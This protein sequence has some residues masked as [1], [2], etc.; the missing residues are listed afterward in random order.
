MLEFKQ[1]VYLLIPDARLNELLAAWATATFHDPA[2]KAR[3]VRNEPSYPQS[4]F[5]EV[6]AGRPLDME[7]LRAIFARFDF[8]GA[9][10]PEDEVSSD[11]AY[12]MLPETVSLALI[13]AIVVADTGFAVSEIVSYHSA[14]TDGVL[15][16]RPQD[17]EAAAGKGQ[18]DDK[19]KLAVILAATNTGDEL[20][21]TQLRFLVDPAEVGTGSELRERVRSAV[22]D[23]LATED[24][25]RVLT[26]DTN[27]H[28]DY[29]DVAGYVPAQFFQRYGLQPVEE[30]AH[31]LEVVDYSD[32]FI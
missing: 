10:R 12:S 21:G 6:E 16:M 5:V 27:G 13:A 24:G 29:G 20:V 9:Y 32:Q 22:R 19:A 28:F 31:I 25:R 23:Y 26:V 3:L 14:E 11:G 2:V 4:I 1:G 18:R 15:A 17:T 8:E 7:N 30:T